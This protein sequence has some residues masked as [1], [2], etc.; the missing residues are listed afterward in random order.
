[1]ARATERKDDRMPPSKK[2]APPERPRKSQV[3]AV[4]P[5]RPTGL[6]DRMEVWFSG[7]T[8]YLKSVRGELKRIVWPDK[9][10]LRAYTIVVLATLVMVTLFL[11]ICDVAFTWVFNRLVGG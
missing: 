6:K 3:A 4:V 5:A 1:M 11:W 7:A 10:A 2:P 9:V 8:R